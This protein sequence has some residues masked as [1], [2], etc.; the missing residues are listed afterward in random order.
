MVKRSKSYGATKSSGVSGV[1]CTCIALLVAALS[2]FPLVWMALA[3]FKPE[4]E[5]LSVPMHLLPTKWVTVSYQT[6]LADPTYNFFHT[7]G[8]TFLVAVLG[9]V[10]SLVVNMMAAYAFARLE[11]RFKKLLWVVCISSMYIPGLTILL[12]S[13]LVVYYL[14][15]LNTIWVLVVP[16]LASGYSIFFFRQFFLNLPSSIEEAAL[17]DGSSRFHIF[18]KI[19]LPL[20]TSPMV[21]M[22]I[23]AFVGYWNSFLWPAMTITTPNLMQ[24]MQI[25]YSLS[26]MYSTNYG[27]VMAAA[28]L[29][30]VLPIGLF[31][32]FQKHIVKGIVLSGLK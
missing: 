4:D 26:S 25:I 11:F 31:L 24:L 17:I 22:G 21:I 2:L 29:V 3:G 6:L 5:V 28:T 10:F 23:G 12:T 7:Y 14:H 13:F 30:A 8:V 9:T 15:M 32:V 27:V 1:V 16:G 19:F 20:S 18:I